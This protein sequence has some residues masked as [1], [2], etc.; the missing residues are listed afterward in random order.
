MDVNEKAKELGDVISKTE[1]YKELE[2][3]S[4]NVHENSEANQM[5]EEIQDLQQKIQFA[6]QSGVQPSPEQIEQYNDLKA[7]MNA[8]LTIKAYA[9]AQ[10]S[11]SQLMQEVNSSISEGIKSEEDKEQ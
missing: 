9:R 3:T 10:E 8:N 4:Q 1:E 5:I 2:R 6:Q 11:F 7:R